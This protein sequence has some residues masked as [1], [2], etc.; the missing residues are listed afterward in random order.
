MC[1]CLRWARSGANPVD[2]VH[3]GVVETKKHKVDAVIVDTAGRL[4]VRTCV[5]VCAR[6]CV[7]MCVGDCVCVCVCMYVTYLCV[8][9][10]VRLCE[11]VGI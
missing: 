2:I 7:Y 1:P 9:V 11:P 3:A 10:W 8:F 4:Q 5:C 6:V